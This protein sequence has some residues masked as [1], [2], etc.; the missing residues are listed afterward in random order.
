F[1][2]DAWELCV[3]RVGASATLSVYRGG[4]E[5]T[6][7]VYDRP[8][9]FS[10]MCA[11][12]V[13]AIDRAIA[14]LEGPVARDLAEVRALLV[15]R[16]GPPAQLR[17]NED[18]ETDSGVTAT[19]APP[20]SVDLERDAPISFAAEFAMRAGASNGTSAEA[21]VERADLH[22]LLVRGRMRAEVRGR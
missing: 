15:D 20:V 12:V 13:D 1:Y 17:R 14:R 10:E 6:V 5:P 7:L 16:S 8:V 18:A 11:S 9:V 4:S 22:A 3:E 2:D 19:F 21:G